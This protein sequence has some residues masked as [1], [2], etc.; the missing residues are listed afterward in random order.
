MSWWKGKTTLGTVQSINT[1]LSPSLSAIYKQK[2]AL[3]PLAGIRQKISS[4]ACY[5]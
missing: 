2:Q 1:F 5:M 3:I 4:L